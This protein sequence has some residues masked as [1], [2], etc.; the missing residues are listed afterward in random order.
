MFRNYL[1]AALRNLLKYKVFSLINILGLSIGLAL[2]MLFIWDELTFDRYLSGD[3]NVYKLELLASFGDVGPQRMPTTA[4][5]TIVGLQADHGDLIENS[6]RL[7]RQ[8][9]NITIADRT[10]N[11]VAHYVDASFFEIFGL[12]Y[13]EGNAAQAMPDPSSVVISRSFAENLF[14]AEPALGETIDVDD[15]NAYRVTAVYE[16]FPRNTHLRPR[17]L[18]PILPSARDDVSDYRGWEMIAYH[19]YVQLKDGVT[20]EDLRAVLRGSILAND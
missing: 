14:G 3:G 10:S 16:D 13:V 6:A 1:T 5:A 11:V 18:F 7:K 8:R 17:I 12:D 19:A 15:G 4:G 9:V 20:G 2:V